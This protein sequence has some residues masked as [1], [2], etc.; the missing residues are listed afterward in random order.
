ML[1]AR[2]LVKHFGGILATDGVSLSVSKGEIRCIIGPNGAGKT[3]LFNLLTG[4]LRPD[5]GEITLDGARIDGLPD[6]EIA[7]R[8]MVRKF[9]VPSVVPD[10]TVE[11]NV[12]LAAAGRAPLR[13][14]FSLRAPRTADVA[15]PVLE[16]VG[17]AERRDTLAGH[18]AHGE[19]Q[20][21]ELAMV[22]VLDPVVLLLDEPTAGMTPQE[23]RKVAALLR[24][25]AARRGL[26]M[27][28]VEHDVEFIRIMGDRITVLHKGQVL[29]EG[30]HAEIESDARVREIYLGEGL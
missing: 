20:L 11:G 26:T 10:L 13:S 5:A 17:L 4:D 29:V 27:V 2:G 14:L 23:T 16:E 6:H 21:L 9:Q 24:E 22:L 7:R 1:E 12:L 25:V 15:L 18:L 3:T 30:T 19:M 8:G 28:I